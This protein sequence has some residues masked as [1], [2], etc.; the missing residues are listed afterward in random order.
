MN[1]NIDAIL[2]DVRIRDLH[3][4]GSST[5]EASTPLSEVYHL[6]EHENRGAVVVCDGKEA[7]GIFTERDVLYRTALEKIDP[8]TPI[9]EL[10]TKAPATLPPA[11]RLADA[12]RLM[13]EGGYRH[14]P[15]TGESGCGAGLLTSRDVLRFI[16][17][18]FSEAVVNLPPHLHQIMD[19]PEGG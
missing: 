5:V 3:L 1:Q 19:H 2:R 17:G 9:S 14:V 7:I 6:L 12:V 8:S 15:V 13:I 16:A 10:M 18:H 4:E 11:A